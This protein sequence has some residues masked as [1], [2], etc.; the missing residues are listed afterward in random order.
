MYCDVLLLSLIHISCTRYHPLSIHSFSVFLSIFLSFL[1]TF[2]FPSFPSCLPPQSFL[3]YRKFKGI[4]YTTKAAFRYGERSVC[5][6]SFC[7]LQ[8]GLCKAYCMSRTLQAAAESS[9]L[10][11][12]YTSYSSESHPLFL[13]G[14]LSV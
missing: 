4:F 13:P 1:F 12:S 8:N 6:I 10:H 11:S 9:I 3:L 5:R 7:T 14:V 2:P